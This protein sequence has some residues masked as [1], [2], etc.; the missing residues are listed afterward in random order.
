MGN[1]GS[2]MSHSVD[3]L[4]TAFERHRIILRGLSSMKLCVWY[5]AHKVSQK[6]FF[7]YTLLIK[8]QHD[9]YRRVI[10][11]VTGSGKKKMRIPLGDIAT[12][13]YAWMNFSCAAEAAQPRRVRLEGWTECNLQS[14]YEA[15]SPRRGGHGQV[16]PLEVWIILSDGLCSRF[17]IDRR[18]DT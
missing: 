3:T 8:N 1:G 12:N 6:S 16:R 17:K 4:Q 5:E 9:K 14:Q 2:K 11:R 15:V 7:F 13:I 18:T 10:P